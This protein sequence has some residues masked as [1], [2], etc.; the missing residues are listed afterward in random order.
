[1]MVFGGRELGV[2]AMKLLVSIPFALF[3]LSLTVSAEL[4]EELAY[5]EAL[6]SDQAELVIVVR[7]F[8]LQQQGLI[9]WDRALIEEYM[10]EG[11]RDLAATK[12]AGIEKRVGLIRTAW[13]YVTERYPNNARALNYYGEFMYDYGREQTRAVQNWRV[14]VQLDD[15]LAAAHN[16]LGIHYFHTGDYRKG[17]DHLQRA[18]VL[19]DDNS[20]FLYNMSQIYLVFF[21]QVGEMLDLPKE[22]LYKEAMRMS[23]KAVE[24]APDDYDVLLDYATNFYAGEQFNV[25][26]DWEAAAHAWRQARAQA[27]TNVQIFFTYLNEGRAWIRSDK[28]ENAIEALDAAAVLRPDSRVVEQLLTK[29]RRGTS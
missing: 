15:K 16:N 21:P 27:S 1:M 28:K 4:P 8:D 10:L 26:I 23:K 25:E 19:E 22:K 5:L 18:L 3:V 17:L 14:A 13:A 20:D 29:A 24:L 2:E 7:R 12:Q 6:A 9:D 11:K